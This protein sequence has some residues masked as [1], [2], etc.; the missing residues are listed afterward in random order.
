[1]RMRVVKPDFYESETVG[2]LSRWARQLLIGLFSYADDNGVQRDQAVSIAS[3]L[4]RFDLATDASE[5]LLAIE[6]GLA[7]LAASGEL[8]RY[9]ID[10]AGYLQITNWALYQNPSRPSKPRFPN[11]AG[12]V[13]YNPPKAPEDH[14]METPLSP[15]GDP[16]RGN[17]NGNGDGTYLHP[18][19][20]PETRKNPNAAYQG[21]RRGA[22]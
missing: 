5:I 22:P 19:R 4:F 20:S 8:K 10:G 16:T 6:E 15:H 18:V 12:V 14:P 13:T 7:E 9:R 11:P 2:A 21:Q 1:M 17:G 3:E